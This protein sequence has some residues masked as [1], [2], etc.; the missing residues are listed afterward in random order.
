MKDAE[1][2]DGELMLEYALGHCTEEDE[3]RISEHIAGCEECL[4]R[5][6]G[7]GQLNDLLDSWTPASH[8]EACRREEGKEEGRPIVVIIV[9][10]VRVLSLP[11]RKAVA[12]AGAHPGLAVAS[13]LI[14]LV[15]LTSGATIASSRNRNMLKEAITLRELLE[16]IRKE[17]AS[18]NKRLSRIH[19]ALESDLDLAFHVEFSVEQPNTAGFKGSI[20]PALIRFVE[21]QFKKDEKPKI[22]WDNRHSDTVTTVL[23]GRRE[24]I[25]D[26][27]SF[28]IPASGSTFERIILRAEYTPEVVRAF[29]EYADA[30]SKTERTCKFEITPTGIKKIIDTTTGSKHERLMVESLPLDDGVWEM[31]NSEGATLTI[32]NDE[33]GSLIQEFTLGDVGEWTN[34]SHPISRTSLADLGEVTAISAR[35][36]WDGERP[37]SVELKLVDNRKRTVGITRF[38]EPKNESQEILVPIQLLRGYWDVKDFCIEEVRRLEFAVARKSNGQAAKGVIKIFNIALLGTGEKITVTPPSPAPEL[39][40]VSLDSS[41]WETK[42]GSRSVDGTT[43]PARLELSNDGPLL[44]CE[45]DLRDD[46]EQFTWT[47]LMTKIEE[48]ENLQAI[49]LKLRW[50]GEAPITIEPMLVTPENGDESRMPQ[51]YGMHHRLHPSEEYQTLLFQVYD[52]KYYF[53]FFASDGKARLGIGISRKAKNQASEG[54]LYIKE[55]MLQG[56]RPGSDAD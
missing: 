51:T 37:L 55:I 31:I 32:S 22:L 39:G 47:N 21:V 33:E 34:L 16:V 19:E 43:V 46:R 41:P 2:I 28:D 11:F 15:A 30:T 27:R 42:V 23:P 1:H 5:V 18:L 8:G 9:T 14:L 40:P 25:H 12:F 56:R 38:V 48:S 7:L 53:P 36:F 44:V 13:L 24:P 20:D 54:T 29:P 49:R 26:N 3:F 35:I 45:V 52:L 50:E 10:A 17:E 6:Q 4:E